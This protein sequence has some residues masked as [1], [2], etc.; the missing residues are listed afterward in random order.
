MAGVLSNVDHVG[1]ATV[2]SFPS[3]SPARIAVT[4]RQKLKSYLVWN[5]AMKPSA[6]ARLT[7]ASRRPVSQESRLC[8][9]ATTRAIR[10]HPAGDPS[11][12]KTG[13]RRLFRGPRHA[14]LL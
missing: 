4:G 5:P 1:S 10:L 13:D 11:N 2:S 3:V 8:D 14:V 12:Q 6:I 9:C 7:S